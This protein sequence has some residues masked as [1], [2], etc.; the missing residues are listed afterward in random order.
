MKKIIAILFVG[1]FSENA[2][3]DMLCTK[4]NMSLVGIEKIIEEKGILEAAKIIEGN[5]CFDS[6]HRKIPLLDKVQAIGGDKLL[7]TNWDFPAVTKVSEGLSIQKPLGQQS[8]ISPFENNEQKYSVRKCDFSGASGGVAVIS[9]KNQNLVIVETWSCA[10][11]GCSYEF[12]YYTDAK[13][14]DFCE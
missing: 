14:K 10:V 4:I 6:V 13:N 3:C 8:F 7:I 11:A 12:T 2:M 9:P 1:V 5:E